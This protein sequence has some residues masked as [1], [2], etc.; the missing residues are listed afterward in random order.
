MIRG[1]DYKTHTPLIY[2][3]CRPGPD[4]SLYVKIRDSEALHKGRTSQDISTKKGLNCAIT[5]VVPSGYFC[6]TSRFFGHTVHAA[7]VHKQVWHMTM[8]L[9]V[10]ACP[11]ARSWD[12]L[13]Q[14]LLP[15]LTI[16]H[17]Q[18]L[19]LRCKPT[20]HF[21]AHRQK[22]LRLFSLNPVQPPF[23][24]KESVFVQ[25]RAVRSLCFG[26]QSFQIKNPQKDMAWLKRELCGIGRRT[27]GKME[28]IR[29][30]SQRVNECCSAESPGHHCW[31]PLILPG[32]TLVNSSWRFNSF[33]A[34]AA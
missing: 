26:V 15:H 5:A 25:R 11:N 32:F 12:S 20:A 13:L 18:R 16:I 22:S 31:S 7:L 4:S 34:N 24:S 6:R 1:N 17:V 19:S 28:N 23:H 21:S 8:A 9:L 2:C 3:C 10:Q 30:V 14:P 33:I 27:C 29:P